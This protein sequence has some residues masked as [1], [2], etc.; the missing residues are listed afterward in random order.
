MISGGPVRP[1]ACVTGFLEEVALIENI[2]Q[3]LLFAVSRRSDPH[4]AAE[5]WECHQR[6]LYT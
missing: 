6:C 2:I 5:L 3:T 1:V 4:E